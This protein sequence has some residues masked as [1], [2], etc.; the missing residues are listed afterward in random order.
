M[1]SECITKLRDKNWIYAQRITEQR[2]VESIARELLC[3][4]QPVRTAIKRFDIPKVRYNE[5]NP[6]VRVKL[7]NPTWLLNEYKTLGKTQQ[8]I[9]D[10]LGCAKSTIGIALDRHGIEAT[11]P[12][13]YDRPFNHVTKPIREIEESIHQYYQGDI[14]SRKESGY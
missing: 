7:D 11:P 14:H 1:T 6:L 8:E 5:A 4:T 2:S 12:N 9:A 3:S 10:L 13:A